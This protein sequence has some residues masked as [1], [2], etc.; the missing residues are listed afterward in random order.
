M[1]KPIF[2]TRSENRIPQIIQGSLE[3]S[4]FFDLYAHTAGW[5]KMLSSNPHYQTGNPAQKQDFFASDNFKGGPVLND[6]LNLS[7]FS[8]RNLWLSTAIYGK[9]GNATENNIVAATAILID[10]DYAGKF[11]RKSSTECANWLLGRLQ[12][13]ENSGL[14]VAYPSYIECGH[15]LRLIYV[16]SSAVCLKIK[17][18]AHRANT[19]RL[20][21]KVTR[22]LCNMVNEADPDLHPDFAGSGINKFIRPAGSITMKRKKGQMMTVKEYANTNGY[23]ST[24]TARKYIPGQ[25]SSW[26]VQLLDWKGPLWEMHELVDTILPTYNAKLKRAKKRNKTH[27]NP[28]VTLEH[29]LKTRLVALRNRQAEGMDVGFREISVFLYW[30]TCLSLGY[31]NAKA[32]RLALDF[33]QGFRTPLPEFV[34]AKQCRPSRIKG[35]KFTDKHFAEYLGCEMPELSGSDSRSRKSRYLD[36]RREQIKAGKTKQ[37]E[38]ELKSS[39]ATSYRKKGKTLQ[40]IA[41]LLNVSLS[42]VKRYLKYK[43]ELS[44]MQKLNQKIK[45]L[46]IEAR[47]TSRQYIQKAKS[48]CEKSYSKDTS[49]LKAFPAEIKSSFSVKAMMNTTRSVKPLD[50]KNSNTKLSANASH[51]K[52]EITAP[53]NQDHC[54]PVLGREML[55]EL[56]A[57]GMIRKAAYQEYASRFSSAVSFSARP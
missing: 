16:F 21:K 46:E 43:P 6:M 13:M 45:A 48:I 4:L 14:P 17:K 29:R 57:Y 25:A 12:D 42:T 7:D 49:L 31:S 23:K 26:L 32:E 40:E 9:K 27:M 19:I 50:G 1:Q 3:A 15:R 36:A 35:Y 20:L 11:E 10:V 53:K 41:D 24:R 2:Y 47:N 52:T 56:Y 30:N 8:R 55:E 38:M 34:A 28:L 54:I 39:L 18:R 44:V 51:K 5:V 37:Q 33:N 22:Y